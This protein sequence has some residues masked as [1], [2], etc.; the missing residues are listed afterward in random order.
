MAQK[1]LFDFLTH[2]EQNSSI[3]QIVDGIITMFCDSYI[4]FVD[5]EDLNEAMV[6]F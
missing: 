5:T 6:L 2:Y 4:T 3:V 1:V